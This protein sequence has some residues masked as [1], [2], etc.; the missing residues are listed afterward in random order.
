M[1]SSTEF[2]Q[3]PNQYGYKYPNLQELHLKL[4]IT[5]F[6]GAHDASNDVYHTA[7]CYWRLRDLGQIE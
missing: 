2:C 4:F 5:S 3:I 1:K 6:K 7:K